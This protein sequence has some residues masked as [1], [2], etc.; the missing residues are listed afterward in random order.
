MIK[1]LS[2]HAEFCNVSTGRILAKLLRR[3]IEDSLDEESKLFLLYE[4]GIVNTLIELL[5][6][7]YLPNKALSAY[8]EVPSTLIQDMEM[9]VNIMVSIYFLFSYDM[10]VME[11]LNMRRI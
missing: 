4:S 3:M 2:R 1:A 9:F 6:K 7:F 10:E 5:P 8:F 11:P